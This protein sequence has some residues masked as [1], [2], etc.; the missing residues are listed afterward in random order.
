MK[1]SMEEKLIQF[2]HNRQA[3]KHSTFLEDPR[4]A[5]ACACLYAV[6]NQEKTVEELKAA[7]ALLKSKVGAFSSFRGSGE[8]AI[9]CALAAADDPEMLLEQSLKAYQYLKKQFLFTDYLP[10]AAVLVAQSVPESRYGEVAERT[11]QIYQLIQKDH[12]VLTGQED[13]LMCVLLALQD[14]SAEQ[15]AENCEYCYQKLKGNFGVLASGDG[16]QSLSEVLAA[17]GGNLEENCN[18]AIDL[19]R[20][21]KEQGSAISNGYELGALGALAILPVNLPQLEAEVLELSDALKQQ[22]GYGFFGIGREG[23]MVHAALLAA[24]EYAADETGVITAIQ[25]T[26]SAIIA[27]EVL[28]LCMMVSITASNASHH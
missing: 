3:I 23:R 6:R 16:I 8:Q 27:E 26:I 17:A 13:E 12:P 19:Y 2:D 24:T 20:H 1:P 25:G 22:K 15:Q 9:I 21:F 5:A 7:K 14:A 28:L 11:R 18:R 10:M 4:I